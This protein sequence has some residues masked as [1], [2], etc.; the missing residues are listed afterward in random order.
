[1]VG[2]KKERKTLTLHEMFSKNVYFE[3]ISPIHY[4][5]LIFFLLRQCKIYVFDFSCNLKRSR[6]LRILINSGFLIRIYISPLSLVHGA[7]IDQTEKIFKRMGKNRLLRIMSSLYGTD[8]TE[9]AFKKVFVREVFKLIYIND[10]LNNIVEKN[11][12]VFIP[13]VYFHIK[14]IISRFGDCELLQLPCKRSTNLVLFFPTALLRLKWTVV[15]LLYV[16]PKIVFLFFGALIGSS[17][18]KSSFRYAI[19][20]DQFFQTKF[21]GRRSF[22]WLLDHREISKHNTVFFL[23]VPVSKKWVLQKKMNGYHFLDCKKVVM[24]SSLIRTKLQWQLLGILFRHFIRLLVAPSTHPHFYRCAVFGLSLFIKWSIIFHRTSIEQYVYTNQEG[25]GQ[26]FINILAR[27]YSVSTWNYST[28]VGGGRLLYVKN[29]SDF[30]NAR[31]ILWSYLNSNHFLSVNSSVIEYYQLHPQKIKNYHSIGCIYSEMV[32]EC[33]KAV[34][35]KDLIE[36]WYGRAITKDAKVVSFFDT[37]FID[38]EE[39]VTNYEDA[40]AFYRDIIEFSVEFDD[41]LMII[42]PSKD[43]ASFVMPSEQWSSPRKGKSIIMLW[44][45]LKNNP[46]VYWAGHC[47]DVPEIIAVSDLVVTHCL[48]SPTVEALGARK[49]AIWYESGDKHRGLAYDMIPGLV[50]H[51][52]RDLVKRARQLLYEVGDDQYGHYIQTHIR[53]KVEAG[54]DGLALTRFRQLLAG[55]SISS[56]T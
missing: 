1:M 5:L 16:F 36:T 30:K 26:I 50:V 12:A 14:K 44:D 6:L 17:P 2:T 10:Y 42:K 34:A 33:S 45:Q 25:F 49:K 51:S 8:E 4:P 9:L 24:S 38:S 43:D 41:V 40:A 52:Y 29:E 55:S 23:N 35:R 54:T 20:L 21:K 3:A 19:A 13:H 11:D 7:A 37:S 18:Q 15:L 28:F 46:N 47:G 53:G 32:K 27:K 39:A 48:S 31:H 22:D 56:I